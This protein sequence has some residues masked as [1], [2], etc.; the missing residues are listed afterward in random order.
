MNKN[1][2]VIS[3][4]V[5]LHKVFPE[6]SA[7]RA[8]IYAATTPFE[9]ILVIDKSLD[10]EILPIA[11]NEHVIGIENTGRGKALVT[12]VQHATG[13]VILI[14]HADTLL[15]SGWDNAIRTALQ[16]EQ[17]IGGGFHISFNV[18]NLYMKLIAVLP[19]LRYY[20]GGELWGDR[21]MFVRAAFVRQHLASLNLPIMEDIDYLD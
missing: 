13:D 18:P 11:S 5:P 19:N 16:D 12:G 14:V 20:A 1:L 3:V 10:H 7:V 6:F 8:S 17:I 15:P 21:A 2:G 9:V 4:V